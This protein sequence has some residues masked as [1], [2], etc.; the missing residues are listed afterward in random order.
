M[1]QVW[2][3]DENG[4]FIGTKFIK[5]NNKVDKD[6]TINCTTGFIK[7]KWNASEW[8]EAATEEETQAWQEEN[9]TEENIQVTEEQQLLSTVLLENAEIKEQLKE[10]QELSSNLM[11]QIAQLKGGNANV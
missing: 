1:I 6:I 4:Y 3:I 9:K 8:V 10:Q 5:E 11:L 7:P 2:T